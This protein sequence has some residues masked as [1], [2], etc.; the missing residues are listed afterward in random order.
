[1]LGRASLGSHMGHTGVGGNDLGPVTPDRRRPSPRGATPS[2][3]TRKG[4][5]VGCPLTALQV[6]WVVMAT[7]EEDDD[8]AATVRP[9]AFHEIE[10][11]SGK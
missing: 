8:K 10:E 7:R 2:G 5:C 4:A 1:M 9:V 3:E 6:G 11:S